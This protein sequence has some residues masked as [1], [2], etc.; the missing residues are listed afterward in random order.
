MVK[1]SSSTLLKQYYNYYLFKFLGKDCQIPDILKIILKS[2]IYGL[3][4]KN[5]ES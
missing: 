3:M 1:V 2:Q 5:S 4:E